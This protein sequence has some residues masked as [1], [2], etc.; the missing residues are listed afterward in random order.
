MENGIMGEAG[1]AFGR[2]MSRFASLPYVLLSAIAVLS[3][4]LGGS[5]GVENPKMELELGFRPDDGSAASGRVSL[6]GK[7]LNPVEDSTPILAKD[8]SGGSSVSFTPEEM[9]AALRQVMARNGKDTSSLKDTTLHFNVVAAAGDK[10][11]F[12]GGF[13]YRRAGKTAGFAD[14]DAFKS[15]KF[16]AFKKT[17][18]LRK[19]VKGF[20]GRLGIQGISLGID[21]IFIPGSPYH[22]SVKKDSSFTMAQMSEGTYGLIGADKDSAL[23]FE[24]TDS[25]STTDTAYS[26]KAWSTIT[27]VPDR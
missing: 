15:G 14:L 24:S 23:L 25:L 4:C 13:S 16:G 18:G 17:Y 21:Y 6:Y 22:A 12:V 11:A 27:F 9:D 7:N 1:K 2:R 10:E 26:A 19:A 5:D 20:H 3:G 8:F